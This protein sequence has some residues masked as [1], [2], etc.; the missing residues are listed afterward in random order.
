MD[1]TRTTANGA[2]RRTRLGACRWDA[3]IETLKMMMEMPSFTPTTP[4]T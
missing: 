3:G 2:S 4:G 1:V